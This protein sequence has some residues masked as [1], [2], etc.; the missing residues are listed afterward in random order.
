[1][2]SGRAILA[3]PCEAR[4][5]LACAL[6]T[7]CT[8]VIGHFVR[9]VRR[10]TAFGSRPHQRHQ[11][12]SPQHSTPVSE[13]TSLFLVRLD[14]S[15]CALSLFWLQLAAD[16]I[17]MFVP[18]TVHVAVPLKVCAHYGHIRCKTSVYNTVN[19]YPAQFR[20]QRERTCA[21]VNVHDAAAAAT[22]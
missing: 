22:R 13:S 9:A 1:M 19:S 10:D 4:P 15:I 11:A 12:V 7:M 6:A 20:E 8:Q 17:I 5:V 21:R 14:S 3:G 2:A 18:G 16:I